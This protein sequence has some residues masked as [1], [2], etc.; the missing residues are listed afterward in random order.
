MFARLDK[1][2]IR[3]NVN[4][5]MRP[6]FIIGAPRTGSTIFYQVMT[7]YF[8]IGYINN[9]MAEF[10]DG[11]VT[12]ARLYKTLF[13]DQL[14]ESTRSSYGRTQ[15]SNAPSECGEF[16]YR[17]FRRDPLYT[18]QGE[19]DSITLNTLR[20]TLGAVETTLEKP[21]LLKNLYC[22]LRIGALSEAFPNAIFIW[23]KRDYLDCAR[24]IAK[25]R[26][27]VAGGITNW[28]S[29]KPPEW[30]QLLSRSPAE[31]IANQIY[32][33]ERHIE[34]DLQQH[35]PSTALR[36]VQYEEFCQSPIHVLDDI[37]V[38]LHQQGISIEATGITIE[39]F[40]ISARQTDDSPLG[41]ALEA[42]IKARFSE[43]SDKPSAVT[44]GC[45]I[46]R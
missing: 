15:G 31:Q 4:S 34:E 5:T 10:P 33:I 23:C 36:C 39:P 45:E 8:R 41:I 21:I 9:F 18:T 27:R 17:F 7:Q 20:S 3:T 42:A 43:A 28:W 19:L 24:S 11:I 6:I 12:A 22:S 44:T 46:P 1:R 2:V 14:H 29:T 40:K 38:W 32:Y 16:W 26:E 35:Y 25:G 37:S 13:K 30:E